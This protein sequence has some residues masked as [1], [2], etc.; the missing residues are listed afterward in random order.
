[1]SD[2]QQ[3]VYIEQPIGKPGKLARNLP[4]VHKPFIVEG[5][6]LFAGKFAFAGTT[7]EKVKGTAG[8]GVAPVGVAVF[9]RYQFNSNLTN[10]L[11]IN[12]GEEVAVYENGFIFA[13]TGVATAGQKVLVDPLTGDIGAG[14]NATNATAGTL[15]FG[16]VDTMTSLN[17]ATATFEIDGVEEALTGLDFS[18]ASTLALVAAVFDAALTGADCAVDGTDLIFTSKTTGNSS[19][20]KLVGGTVMTALGT[21]VA[22]DGANA[23]IDTGWVIDVASDVNGVA[24]IRK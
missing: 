17:A 15:T 1:M 3:Q 2:F 13:T 8:A 22:V 9:A 24:V 7:A 12:K 18:S 23:M 19:S 10:S 5:N 4:A 11:L 16:D 6:E 14:D 21:G 20:V